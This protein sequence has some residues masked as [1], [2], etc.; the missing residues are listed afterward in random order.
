MG[1]LPLPWDVDT[2]VTDYNIG[3]VVNMTIEWSGTSS[4]LIGLCVCLQAPTY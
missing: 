3:A 2:L 4:S 1:S